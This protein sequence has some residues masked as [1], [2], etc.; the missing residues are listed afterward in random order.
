MSYDFIDVNDPA[1]FVGRR[2]SENEKLTLLTSSLVLP[3]GF[4]MEAISGRRFQESWTKERPWLRY[5][6][7]KN[8]AFCLYCICFG[9]FDI[10]N[11]NISPFVSTGFCK[12]KKATGKKDS[13]LDNHM[14]GDI[15]K[16]AEQKVSSFSGTRQA[17]T[18]IEAK[19]S[20]Q[21]SEE[22]ARTKNGIL[23]IIDIVLA[24]GMRGIPFRGNWIKEDHVEVG[25]FAFFVK[26][27][28][29][30]DMALDDHL[31]HASKSAKF[32]SPRI[33]NEI[34]KICEVFIREKIISKVPKYWSIMVDETTD[35]SS[36]EQLSICIRFV[37]ED[38]EV[39][40]EF[41]G[42]QNL[43][44]MD[45]QSIYDVLIMALKTWGLNLSFL[46]GQGYDGC[47]VM[48]GSKNGLA[49]KI[50]D[51]YPNAVY[52]HCRSH[53]LNLAIAGA[54]KDVEPIRDLFGNVG[55]V[56]SFLR[57][58]AKRNEIFKEIAANEDNEFL[59]LLTESEEQS[60][61]IQIPIDEDVKE[62]NKGLKIGAGRKSVPKLCLTRWSAKFDTISA[63]I[64]K[65]PIVLQTLSSIAE[66]SKGE[67]RNTAL[68]YIRLLEDSQFIVALVVG[69]YVLSF[70]SSVTK[71]L[72]AKDCNLGE[73]YADIQRAKECIQNARTDDVWN[74][75][76]ARIGKIAETIG[77]EIKKPRIVGIQLYRA[78]AG[79]SEDQT[80]LNYFKI[81]V[82]FKFID[83]VVEELRTRFDNTHKGLI[84][85]QNLVP[86]SLNLMT[87]EKIKDLLDYYENFLTFIEKENIEAEISRWKQQFVNVLAKEKPKT[88]N[89]ALIQC[90]V[91]IYPAINKILTIFLTVPVGSVPCER[92]F[93][94]LRRL[95]LWTRAS[96][97]EERLSGLAM[98]M[99]HSGSEVIPTPTEVYERKA[100][101]RQMNAE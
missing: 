22:Q 95:K 21:I 101:W 16:D 26:W 46:V 34:I 29:N 61:E 37:T 25:N 52:V 67:P 31:K 18:D 28:A 14:K 99:I 48:S 93:S 38:G 59:T 45:A 27:K 3:E 77:V 1:L 80:P 19:L 13:Y 96:M 78:N 72:Q 55:K 56:T 76:W 5:S 63:I 79:N 47:S 20:K 94:G 84:T 71:L 58:G 88:A 50:L 23:S 36:M 89:E 81:N 73:A 98:L 42:F 9:T 75:V 17:G 7:S 83:H 32:T 100:N 57:D 54:C 11:P 43:K 15:H 86:I 39:C 92:S 97:S 41:L 51:Q 64:A 4:K 82:Y 35:V 65:Y 10:I 33:Q 70:T 53:V 49:R 8:K 60:D 40:E 85:A 66:Q 24:L 87:S 44:K 91:G 12:W 30:F 68:A 74:K 62:S 2:L 69:Q 6:I 90:S